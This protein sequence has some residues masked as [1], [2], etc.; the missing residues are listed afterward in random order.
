MSYKFITW[1]D[2]DN[3]KE[4][5]SILDALCDGRIFSIK[6]TNDNTVWINDEVDECF[7]LELTKDQLLTL[8]DEISVIATSLN[9]T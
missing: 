3:E 2:Y 8:C 9:D 4:Y 7:S 5:E 1:P 6:K